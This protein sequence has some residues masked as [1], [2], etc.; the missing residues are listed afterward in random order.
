MLFSQWIMLNKNNFRNTYWSNIFVMKIIECCISAFIVRL[1][2]LGYL[3][4]Q[5]LCCNSSV[6]QQK[7]MVGRSAS[8]LNRPY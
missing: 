6:M 7:E 4:Q 8:E 2:K 5:I 1:G 3:L